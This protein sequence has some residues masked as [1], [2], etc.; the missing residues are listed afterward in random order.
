MKIQN[1]MVINMK[2]KKIK[3]VIYMVFAVAI[4]STCQNNQQNSSIAT[5]TN[6][7]Q[8]YK[9]VGV[10]KLIDLANG[11]ITID[12]ED[13]AGYMSAMQMNEAV[14]DKSIL[15]TIKIGDKVNFEIERT[16]EKIVIINLIKIGEVV[17]I[18]GSEIYQTNCAI[19]H[20]A[21]G[22]G[23][24]K[25]I[26]LTS[27][28]ALA[29]TQIEYIKQVTDGEGKRMPAF[30]DKLSADQI[31]AVAKYVREELQKDVTPEQREHHHH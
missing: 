21:N 5:N 14:G 11:K 26:P 28:H 27:G 17:I 20:G 16:G 7:K 23:E 18:N 6:D 8:I 4:F 10:V 9:A 24:K 1:E 2:L 29:H 12:H 31:T 22:E 30:K 25:G 15:E 13:I 3:I 19:C